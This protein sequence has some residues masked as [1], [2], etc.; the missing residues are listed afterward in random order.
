MPAVTAMVAMGAVQLIGGILGSRKKRKAEARQR[1]EEARSVHV[2]A[3]EQ[4]ESMAYDQSL[5]NWLERKNRSRMRT[6]VE[7]WGAFGQ[8]RSGRSNMPNMQ[9]WSRTTPQVVATDPGASPTPTGP[10]IP[11]TQNRRI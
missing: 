7:N 6:G 3:D 1:E 5:K 11:I 4:R 8:T 10:T 2:R 9:A